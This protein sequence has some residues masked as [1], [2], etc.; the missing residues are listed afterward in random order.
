MKSIV[1]TKRR[2]VSELEIIIVHK[3]Q[4]FAERFY[5]YFYHFHF[6]NFV[7]I[8]CVETINQD[9]FIENKEW[10]HNFL[11]QILKTFFFQ[12]KIF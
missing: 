5:L 2:V 1:T 10:S 11:V 8:C 6:G 4:Q 7:S 12:H 3:P 9:V